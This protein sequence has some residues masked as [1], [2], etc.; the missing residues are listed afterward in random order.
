[1]QPFFAIDRLSGMQGQPKARPRSLHGFTLVEL[2]VVIAIIGVL[3]GLLL[4]AVQAARESAR[5]S[6]CQANLRQVSLAVLNYESVRKTFPAGSN[7]TDAAMVRTPDATIRRENWVVSV[8]PFIEEEALSQRYDRSQ[9]P[10]HANNAAVRGTPITVMLCPS[11]SF[12]R[13]PFMGSAGGETA[14]YQDTWQRGNYGANGSLGFYGRNDGYSGSTSEGWNNSFRRCVMGLNRA[15]R[16]Q[17]ITDGL[18]K[19]CLL[20]ELRAGVTPADPRGVWALGDAGSSTLWSHGGS[21][22]GDSYGPNCKAPN[23]DD[24]ANCAA[25]Q[26]ASGGASQLA[27]TGMSCCTNCGPNQELGQATARSMHADGVFLSMCDGSVRWVP[28]TINTIPSTQTALSV[29]DR[30]MLSADGQPVSDVP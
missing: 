20:A 23:A 22:F 7:A 11:D 10:A 4:P 5:R 6:S 19:T 14:S 8:L 16:P 29:W 3:I 1:M 26:E 30:L 18:S 27:E 17:Q 28:D 9:S 25:I 21:S 15:V 13:R 12:N 2:L 24:I